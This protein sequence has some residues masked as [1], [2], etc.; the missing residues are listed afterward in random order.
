MDITEHFKKGYATTE[1]WTTIATGALVLVN[2]TTSLDLNTDS[3][4]AL[5]GTV[6]AYILSRGY[7]KG[8]RV[9]AAGQVQQAQ[10]YRT[11]YPPA[12]SAP[13]VG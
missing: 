5:I 8:K 7:L 9:E 6:A 1:F 10:E 11:S 2:G 12:P 13:P 4:V 3:I